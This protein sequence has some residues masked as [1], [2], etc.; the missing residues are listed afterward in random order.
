MIR[1]LLAFL[2]TALPAVSART[3]LAQDE[4]AFEEPA[5][6][7]PKPK[8]KAVKK[9]E[10][11]S[12]YKFTSP[13]RP[14]TNYRFDSEGNPIRPKKKKAKKKPVSTPDDEIDGIVPAQD[15]TLQSDT[16]G[17]KP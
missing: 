16:C 15:C 2:L 8:K 5:E 6:E 10:K 1:L 12:K 9:K 7:A 13:D 14:M 3:V 11:P 17:E 4:P